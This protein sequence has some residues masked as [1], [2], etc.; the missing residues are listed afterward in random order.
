M[1]NTRRRA[2]SRRIFPALL[3]LSLLILVFGIWT[4]ALRNAAV[5]PYGP[6]ADVVAGLATC[7]L[8]VAAW[9]LAIQEGKN[10]STS[11]GPQSSDI[12]RSLLESSSD[13]IFVKDTSLRMVFCNPALSRAV[14]KAPEETYSKTDIENGWSREQVKGD[15][16]KGIKGWEKDDLAALAGATIRVEREPSDFGGETRYYD[17]VKMPLRD[18]TGTITGIL[19]VGRDVTERT[20][21]EFALHE[22]EE[23]YRSLFENMLDGFAFCRMIFEND[24][25]V[26]FV[27]LKTN[28]AFERLTGLR[29]IDGKRVSEVI[30]GIR[31][32]NPEL[33]ETY[34]RVSRTGTPEKLQTYVA[35]LNIWFSISVYS[36]Q[37]YHFVA[38][39]EN[40]TAARLMET[41][42]EHER[43]LLTTLINSLPDLVYVKDR[44]SRFVLANR[45]LARFMGAAEPDDIVGKSDYDFH[46]REMADKFRADERRVMEQGVEMINGE[47]VSRSAT[48]GMRW[49]LTTKVPLRDEKGSVIGL[50]GSGHDITRRKLDELKQREQAALLEIATDAIVVRD[51]RGRILFWNRSASRI[52]GWTREEAVGQEANGLMFGAAASEEAAIAASAVLATGEWSGEQHHRRKDGAQIIVEARWTRV[53]DAEGKPS[54]VLTVNTDVS[55]RKSIQAQLLRVQR[56]ESLGTLAGG[57]AHDLNNVLAPILMGI[58]GLAIEHTDDKTRSILDIIRVSAERGAGIVRQVLSFARGVE[59]ARGEVQLKHILREIEQMVAETF[60]RS[61]QIAT[62][63]PK[64]L[65][66]IVG[67][68]TQLHQVL[69]NLCVNARDAMPDGGMLTLSA[70]VICLD[71]TYARMHVDARPIRYVVLRVEDTGT[72]MPPGVMERIF[73]PFFT[74]KEPGKGTGLGLSTALTIARSHGG[75]IS[76][77]SEV[78]RGSSFEVFL[79]AV[80]QDAPEAGEQA[81]EGLPMGEGEL[82]LV[83]DDEA[84]VREITRQILDSYGYRALTA[85]DGAEALALFAQRK[86][87]VRAVITDMMMPYMDGAGMIRA[88]KRMDPGV[89]IIST[90][91]MAGDERGKV[92]GSLDV[93][94]SIAKPYTAQTLL[95]TL[96]QVLQS[97]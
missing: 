10:R 2:W 14:G 25:P 55:E 71:E 38:V 31:E 67:D 23:S 76:V 4:A 39:F 86:A 57:I 75:F 16:E 90:S 3:G 42:I 6:L 17:T 68:V 32:S 82:I 52:Y 19:G 44:E 34:G 22:S 18:A 24:S 8:L 66:P 1:S 9:R 92:V 62:R 74:T 58:E 73:D 89:K 48:G 50:V 33:F 49:L 46:T 28:T 95:E 94:A 37:E 84:A 12:L 59:G 97:A 72:G 60:P 87:D 15:P 53:A 80:E 88:L 47:E 13:T 11:R 85:A 41:K 45:A 51:M 70:E 26:D 63:V 27:Y 30:P 93:A 64:D 77:H 61:I 21:A 35:P 40:I 69:M 91:G 96:R 54:G 65:P 43:A 79:P 81:A 20:K 56:L 5:P 36:P 78:G 83:V 29:N 7:G